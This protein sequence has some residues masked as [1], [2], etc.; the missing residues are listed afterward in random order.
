MKRKNILIAVL[1]DRQPVID[2][3]KALV[4]KHPYLKIGITATAPA[5]LLFQM[6]HIPVDMVL[7]DDTM[8]YMNEDELIKKIKE[9]SPQIKIVA[10]IASKQN[11][12]INK[13]IQERKVAGAVLKHCDKK[14][15]YASLEK[16]A[17]NT[18]YRDKV[19]QKMPKVHLPEKESPAIHLT[20]RELEVI[21]LIEQE[22][23]NKQIA[24]TLVIS[25]RTVETHRKNIFRKTKTNSVIGLIKYAYEH[26]LV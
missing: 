3:I 7:A 2:H 23:S 21:R 4:E 22:Y 18:W 5:N 12:I 8:L 13:M 20:D 25:E 16:I 26:K 15:L 6:K 9:L 10:L 1:D 17:D 11:D 24:Q 19:L 14:M